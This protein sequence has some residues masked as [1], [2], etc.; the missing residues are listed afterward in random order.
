MIDATEAVL[1]DNVPV[2]T[3]YLAD[4][5]LLN[6]LPIGQ[7]DGGSFPLTLGIPIS[8]SNL[9]PP[10]PGPP[11]GVISVGERAT[12]TFDL[13]VNAGVPGGTLITNQARVLTADLPD[14]LTDGDGNPATG[15]EPTI[16]IVGA[17]QQLAISKDVNVVGGGPALAGSRLEYIVRVTNIGTVAANDVVLTDDLDQPV[18][19]EMTYVAGSATLDGSNVGVTVFGSV[20]TADYSTTNGPLPPGAQITLRFLV[21][22]DAAL[23]MGTIVTNTGVVQ[24]NAATQMETASVS[25]AIGGTPGVGALN[26]SIWHDRNFDRVQ[27]TTEIALDGWIVELDRNGQLAATTTTGS[28]GSYRITGVAPTT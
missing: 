26:G 15:P 22:L 4:T 7:P 8:S 16:V 18:A 14:L 28:N 24:W 12:V 10:V 19:G 13:E 25:F 3:T 1:V 27:D 11:G 6:G 20:I 17:G 23:A 21:D 9:T 2:N 5:V